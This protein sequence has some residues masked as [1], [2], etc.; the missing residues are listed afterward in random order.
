[1]PAGTRRPEGGAAVSTPPDGPFRLESPPDRLYDVD[2]MARKYDKSHS[3]IYAML[4]AGELPKV[5][6]RRG[7]KLF[8]AP[9]HVDPHCE[10]YRRLGGGGR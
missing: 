7:R 10:R 2:H 8:W 3:Q 6:K 5:W 4:K 9:E 1:M